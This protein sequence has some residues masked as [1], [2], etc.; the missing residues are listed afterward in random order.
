MRKAPRWL[1]LLSLAIVYCKEETKTP[2][3]PAKQ[4]ASAPVVKIEAKTPQRRSNPQCV[5]PFTDEPKK[6]IKI[7]ARE[8]ELRGSTLVEKTTDPDETM[9][10]G[11]IA[12]LKED[13][14]ENLGNIDKF[15]SAF[16]QEKV[17][18]ILVNGD[19]GETKPQVFNNL[20]RIAQSGLPVGIIIGNRECVGDF[21]QAVADVAE[22]AKNVFNL[23]LVRHIIADDAEFV[24]MPGYYNGAYLHCTSGCQYYE[25]DVAALEPLIAEAKHPI[26]LV[27]HGPPRQSGNFAI[28]KISEGTNEGDPLLTKLISEHKIPFGIFAN[29]HEAGGKATDLGGE[30][31]VRENVLVDALYLNSGPG[32]SVR[33]TMNGGGESI[34]MAA[35]VTLKGKYASYQVIRISASVAKRR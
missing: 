33:W 6:A 3:E 35:V 22:K 2:T 12:D 14:P 15:L 30:A 17:E 21:N 26:T 34:G 8:W 10:I 20:K 28:D 16:K 25:E 9:V 19:T 7:G 5:G 4:P 11:V 1:L 18:M 24:T 32:D 27:S 13:T 29:I 31:V 23:N